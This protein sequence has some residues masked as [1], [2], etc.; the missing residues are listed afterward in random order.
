M[1]A[2]MQEEEGTE[3]GEEPS[4]RKRKAL[5][6]VLTAVTARP[7]ARQTRRCCRARKHRA[8]SRPVR[9]AIACGYETARP[10]R[11]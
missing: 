10:G 9:V 4:D 8:R 1:P 7:R 6:K 5:R 2:A 11:D 3:Q